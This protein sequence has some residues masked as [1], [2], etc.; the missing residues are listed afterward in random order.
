MAGKKCVIDKSG[1]KSNVTLPRFRPKQGAW[2]GGDSHTLYAFEDTHSGTGEPFTVV[3]PGGGTKTSSYMKGVGP[4]ATV[5]VATKA[6][7][8]QHWQNPLHSGWKIA[9]GEDK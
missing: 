5:R 8:E 1:A 2:T 7:G 6:E 4:N 9:C 3:R